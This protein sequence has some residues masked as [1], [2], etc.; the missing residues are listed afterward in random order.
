MY[1][2]NECVICK[3]RT[4][5][6]CVSCHIVICSNHYN[7][8]KAEVHRWYKTLSDTLPS[9][10]KSIIGYLVIMTTGDRTVAEML[11]TPRMSDSNANTENL[12]NF[13]T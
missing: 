10:I 9:K 1:L 2:D 6:I 11:E 4:N 3:T 8:H 13:E 5:A 12:D 7:K